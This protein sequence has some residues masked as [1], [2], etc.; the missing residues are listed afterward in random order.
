MTKSGSD[1]SPRADQ[2]TYRQPAHGKHIIEYGGATGASLTDRA[3]ER[4]HFRKEDSIHRGVVLEVLKDTHTFD[5]TRPT[6]NIKF[7]Q[8]SC[9]SLSEKTHMRSVIVVYF[10]TYD[11]IGCVVPDGCELTSRAY[12][13]SEKTIILSPRSS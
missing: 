5:L 12:T 1:R 6:M 4:T 13:L 3:R 8:F 9:I 10:C 7:A 2:W 11:G